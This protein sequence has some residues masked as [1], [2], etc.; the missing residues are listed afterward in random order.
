MY[1]EA[2]E[3]LRCPVAPYAPLILKT[4][5]RQADD[6]AILEG[7]LQSNTGQRY[8]IHKGI[9]DFIKTPFPSFA[10]AQ[11]VNYLPPTAW[12]YERT[13]RPH[14]LSLL[15]G[16]PFGYDRELALITKLLAPQRG[17]LFVDIACSNGLYA[18]AIDRIRGATPGH[19]IGLDHSLPMVQEA[20]AFAQHTGQRITY[21]RASAQALPFAPG[22]ATG[23]AIGGSLN[24]IGDVQ[25]CLHE[26]RR[27]AADDGRFVL[28]NLVQAD[29]LPGR[30]LQQ[31]LGTGGIDF[32]PQ[33]TLNEWFITQGWQRAAQWR[34]GVVLFTLLRP[35]PA[36]TASPAN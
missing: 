20:R 11:L 1:P 17:G 15:T 30:L 13:W 21:I 14:S 35:H 32:W 33:S 36:A 9:V 5:T 6:G 12:A 18:R 22:V 27:I 19:V 24:E 7:W 2:L 31:F 23:I 3:Y 34:Y 28:M 25:T 16:E 10:P 26:A 29:S 4:T 8:P